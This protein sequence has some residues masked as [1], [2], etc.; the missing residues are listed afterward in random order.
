MQ[1]SSKNIIQKLRSCV[2]MALIIFTFVVG[3][4]R[5]W[6][7]EHRHFAPKVDRTGQYRTVADMTANLGGELVPEEVEAGG[8][9]VLRD[10]PELDPLLLELVELGR[11]LASGLLGPGT[12]FLLGR[13]LFLLW[14]SG[15]KLWDGTT[16]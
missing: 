5:R 8:H 16:A 2:K 13:S 12:H 7:L 1:V 3:T 6:S 11:D 9:H 14:G 4:L 10:D 15:L